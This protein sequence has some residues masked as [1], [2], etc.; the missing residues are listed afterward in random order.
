MYVYVNIIV[1]IITTT[2]VMIISISRIIIQTSHARSF[3]PRSPAL[4]R[5]LRRPMLTPRF[6][7]LQPSGTTPT[8]RMAIAPSTKPAV[9]GNNCFMF[10]VACLG[11][12]LYVCCFRFS[13]FC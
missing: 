6:S 4:R 10:P 2:I 5:F 1:L 9:W 7:V 11:F 12:L 3:T 13:V 8:P